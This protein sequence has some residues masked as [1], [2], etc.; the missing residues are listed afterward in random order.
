MRDF[1]I[2]SLEMI[3]NIVVILLIIGVVVATIATWM[4]PAYAG[5][6]FLQ[7]LLI[8][9]GG[10]VYTILTGGMLYLF[11]GIYQNTKKT[12]EALEQRGP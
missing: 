12:A 1:F 5:G 10:A 8:L 9:V 11:L 4:S 7:G 6:G 2:N 3:V